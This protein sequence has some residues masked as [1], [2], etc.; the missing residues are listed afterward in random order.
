MRVLVT[1]EK[2]FIASN[3]SK[4]LLKHDIELI[5]LN[6]DSGQILSP[7]KPTSNDEL[8]VY[9]NTARSWALLIDLHKID[10]IIHNAAVVGTDV[11]A[12]DPN[13]ATATNIA[14]TYN[15]VQAANQAD[16]PIV[17][18]G[19]TVIYNTKIYQDGL[20]YE[21]SMTGPTT[22]YG[23]LKLWAEQ[24][25]MANAKKWIVLRPLFAYGGVGDMNSLMAKTFY[26]SMIPK[27]I[28][29]FL[30]PTKYKDYL[31]VEDFCDTVALACK[32]KL[33]ETRYYPPTDNY[34]N[35]YNIAAETPLITSEI[36][37][38][39]SEISGKD[40]KLLINWKP[41]TD[42]LGNHRLSTAK[43]RGDTEWMP[44][45]TL[46]D[47]LRRSHSSIIKNFKDPEK[48]AYNPLVYLDEAKNKGVDLTKF[49]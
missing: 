48:I 24:Y 37:E 14:G 47:G 18:L 23:N 49:Y 43:F 19:T 26:S 9:R 15:I 28:D 34:G 30:D 46:E 13:K 41:E 8:C 25:V 17:Y 4:S 35:D 33:Y 22:F 6:S 5:K 40:L 44:K 29:M 20:I 2:G 11:V 12:L 27:K 31:H 38:L 21:N 45:I 39:M 36:V 32:K 1:G 7:G 3:L 10:M 42:Y 16:I